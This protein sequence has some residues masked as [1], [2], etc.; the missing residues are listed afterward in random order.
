MENN[1]EIEIRKPNTAFAIMLFAFFYYLFRSF[2]GV[3]PQLFETVIPDIIQSNSLLLYTIFY[4]YYFLFIIYG[5]WC[6]VLALKGSK[7]A[8]ASLKLCLPFHFIALL[9]GNISTISDFNSFGALCF[10][11]LKILFPLILLIYVCKSKKVNEFIPKQN[12]TIGISGIVGILLYVLFIILVIYMAIISHSISINSNKI[13]S[14]RIELN[15]GEVTDG[16]VIFKPNDNWIQDSTVVLDENRDAFYFHDSIN[17]TLVSVISTGGLD[18]SP[19]HVYIY[20]IPQFQP[21]NKKYF[22]KELNHVAFNN[23]DDVIYIDQYAYKIDS[24]PYYWTLASK[25][26]KKYEKNIRISIVEK[27]SLKTTT[28]DV[29]DFLD[30]SVVDIKSRLLEKDSID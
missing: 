23:D 4:I 21:F 2:I 17:Q 30:K 16:R 5:F 8:I 6:V 11:I 25:L 20:D 7:N 22:D 14:R 3:I 12:R 28:N 24:V 19:R 13:D 18:E 29:I 15:N 1:K 26:S 10:L 9:I 27:D